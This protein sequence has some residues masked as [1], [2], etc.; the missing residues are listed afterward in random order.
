MSYYKIIRGV[1][2]DRELLD[3]ADK[4]VTGAGDGRISKDDAVTLWEE[5]QDGQGVTPT[6]SRTLQYILDHYNCTTAA[7][8]YLSPLLGGGPPAT[9]QEE[10]LSPG[11]KA[12]QAGRNN[13]VSALSFVLCFSAQVSTTYAF[14]VNGASSATC[15]GMC[16]AANA[17]VTALVINPQYWSTLASKLP[18]VLSI[19]Q[20]SGLAACWLSVVAVCAVR[21]P[22]LVLQASWTEAIPAASQGAAEHLVA[23][24]GRYQLLGCL[25][26]LSAA[27]RKFGAADALMGFLAVYLA[28]PAASFAYVWREQGDDTVDGACLSLFTVLFLLVLFGVYSYMTDKPEQTVAGGAIALGLY[29][30]FMM[31]EPDKYVHESFADLKSA[32]PVLKHLSLNLGVV[33]ASCA[34]LLTYASLD[35]KQRGGEVFPAMGMVSG[36]A[37]LVS[38]QFYQAQLGSLAGHSL[39]FEPD[40]CLTMAHLLVLCCGLLSIANAAAPHPKL[41]FERARIMQYLLRALYLSCFGAA[42]ALVWRKQEFESASGLKP[43]GEGLTLWLVV[44]NF[45]LGSLWA[46]A[47]QLSPVAQRKVLQYSMSVPLY[48]MLA[49]LFFECDLVSDLIESK[50][51]LIVFHVANGFLVVTMLFACYYTKKYKFSEDPTPDNAAR[52]NTCRML[53]V[54]ALYF[55]GQMLYAGPPAIA[56][57]SS[58]TEWKMHGLVD[59]MIGFVY[60]AAAQCDSGAQKKLLQYGMA[61]TMASIAVSIKLYQFAPSVLSLQAINLITAIYACYGN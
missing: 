20:F 11:G 49:A 47:A 46:A 61:G 21:A 58:V 1:R 28:K 24:T 9:P 42:G 32:S 60:I 50:P 37:V 48:T 39:P 45:T 6:E 13:F 59:L 52:A 19:R 27:T 43:L 44:G 40:C 16:T 30:C 35:T 33:M 36:L 53:Y 5:A 2:Y 3:I 56:A 25:V 57:A 4:L 10:P 7:K 14:F 51:K 15:F 18:L 12:R 41:V 55:G 26:M 22:E 34:V 31:M 17:A 38:V 23:E 8:A 29:A 54:Q